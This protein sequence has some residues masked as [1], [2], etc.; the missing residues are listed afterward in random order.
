[1]KGEAPEITVSIQT[2]PRC[3]YICIGTTFVLYALAA[4]QQPGVYVVGPTFFVAVGHNF[5]A[6][7]VYLLRSYVPLQ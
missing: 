7:G 4:A 1:M 2:R 6:L 5:G 3:V